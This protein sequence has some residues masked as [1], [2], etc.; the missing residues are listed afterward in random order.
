MLLNR[1]CTFNEATVVLFETL[2][3]DCGAGA[4][5]GFI[6]TPLGAEKR[7]APKAAAAILEALGGLPSLGLVGIIGDKGFSGIPFTS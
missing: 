7:A 2:L 6:S 5:G 4:L 1:L 3:A